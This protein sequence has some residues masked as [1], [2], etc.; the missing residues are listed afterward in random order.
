MQM[1]SLG[2]CALAATLGAASVA[3]TADDPAVARHHAMEQVGDAMKT[4]GGMARGQAPFAAATVKQNATTI[5]ERLGESAALF[6]AGSDKG[7][8]R[9]KAEIWANKADFDKIMADGKAAA[10][11]L[12]AVTDE[13]AYRPALGALGQNCKACHDKYRAPE[14]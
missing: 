3:L 7:T 4:L 8:T 1:R 14:K 10:T 9:A 6:P 5:A 11:A 13:A 2:L 12:A